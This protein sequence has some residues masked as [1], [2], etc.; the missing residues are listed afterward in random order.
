MPSV[1]PPRASVDRAELTRTGA[2]ASLAALRGHALELL[3]TVTAG[4]LETGAG[5][6]GTV[7]LNT[8]DFERVRLA[9]HVLRDVAEVSTATTL[10]GRRVASPLAV[11]PVGAHGLFHPTAECGT[12]SGADAA[13]LPMSLSAYSNTPIE[14][15]ARHTGAGVWA[16]INVPPDRQYLWGFLD[17]VQHCAEA[18][19]ITVDTPVVGARE[20]QVWDGLTLPDGLAYPMQDGLDPRSER[21]DSIYRSALDAGFTLSVLEDVVE[22]SPLPV[23]VKGFLRG[24]DARA[25]VQAGAAAVIVSNHGGRNL[26]SGLSTIRAL[27][28]VSAAVDGQVPVLIDGGIRRGT[29][30]L[31]ALA[32]GA[33]GVLVGRPVMWG[34]TVGGADGVQHVLSTLKRELAM[35]MALC[36]VRT[37]DD[38]TPDLIHDQQWNSH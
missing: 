23:I 8:A 25:A 35:A 34:L 26:D 30:I 37:V 10:L 20:S 3:P 15:V 19:V 4:Y 27:P 5:D 6:Q 22:R 32:L 17:R 18:V 16:Q 7:H 38:I 11:A 14:Q 24:D 28:A 9:P 13:G 2:S 31:K 29:D 12:A 1:V 36:G 33:R 21:G